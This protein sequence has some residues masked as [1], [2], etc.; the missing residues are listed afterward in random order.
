MTEAPEKQNALNKFVYWVKDTKLKSFD[1]A[2]AIKG[3]LGGKNA[4][5]LRAICELSS[6]GFS[7][8]LLGILVPWYVRMQT[9]KKHQKELAEKYNSYHTYP[10]L[11]IN[12]KKTFQA[13][14]MTAQTR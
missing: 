6:L 7:M 12:N 2:N 4:K 9:N 14:G 3:P 5:G 13:F 1:E 10:S 11:N 8:L